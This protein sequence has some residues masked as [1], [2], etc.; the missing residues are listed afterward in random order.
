MRIRVLSSSH[1]SVAVGMEGE[2]TP[3]GDGYAVLFKGFKHN[4][5]AN[6]KT[7]PK[8]TIVYMEKHEVELL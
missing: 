8:D 2:A 5:I 6:T 4:A 1:S 7:V 3:E